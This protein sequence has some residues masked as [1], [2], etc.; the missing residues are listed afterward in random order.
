M[1]GGCWSPHCEAGFN[2]EAGQHAMLQL[3]VLPLPTV[4]QSAMASCKVQPPWRQTGVFNRLSVR[5]TAIVSTS[6]VTGPG[7]LLMF[8]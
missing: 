2:R 1:D 6:F 7:L 8:G 4:A 3:V 5:G